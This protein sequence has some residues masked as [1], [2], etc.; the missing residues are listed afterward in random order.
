MISI[1]ISKIGIA[2]MLCLIYYYTKEIFQTKWLLFAVIIWVMFLF[3]EIGQA[4]GPNYSWE[5]AIAG[6]ISETIYVPLSIFVLR[7]I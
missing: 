5:E 6:I 7:I 4:I 3:G 1:F 2:I